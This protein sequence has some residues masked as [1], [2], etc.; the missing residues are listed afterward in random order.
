MLMPNE[1]AE[2]YVT[3]RIPTSIIE[4][5]LGLEFDQ[6]GSNES[7]NLFRPTE[8]RFLDPCFSVRHSW[9]NVSNVNRTRAMT[10]VQV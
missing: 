4:F 9:S 8:H 1:L 5:C 10:H 3:A 7:E 2:T 6:S